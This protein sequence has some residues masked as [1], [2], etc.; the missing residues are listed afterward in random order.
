MGSAKASPGPE[1]VV[2]IINFF[3][4]RNQNKITAK[5]YEYKQLSEVQD[6]ILKFPENSQVIETINMGPFLCTISAVLMSN[7]NN[8]CVCYNFLELQSYTVLTFKTSQV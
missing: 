8:N 3:T 2:K 6:F 1:N 4:L 5:S 7:R